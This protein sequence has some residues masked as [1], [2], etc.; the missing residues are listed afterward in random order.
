MT[1]DKKCFGFPVA[2]VSIEAWRFRKRFRA[3]EST[4]KFFGVSKNE[5]TPESSIC[6]WI[7]HEINHGL[8]PL[9]KISS[10]SMISPEVSL[11]GQ[12][13]ACPR[14]PCLMTPEG[15]KTRVIESH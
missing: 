14:Q 7:F 9:R 1:W 13:W 5:G 10:T 6:R 8:L 2:T 11:R 4:G 12:L 15:K 3:G